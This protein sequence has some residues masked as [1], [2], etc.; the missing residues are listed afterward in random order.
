MFHGSV[1]PTPVSVFSSTST[2]PF[3]LFST[4]RDASLPQE[5]GLVLLI[6]STDSTTV[7]T[8]TYGNTLS[9]RRDPAHFYLRK[10]NQFLEPDQVKRRP[11]RHK[12]EGRYCEKE[13]GERILKADGNTAAEGSAR[14]VERGSRCEEV[15]ALLDQTVL[16]LQ[17]PTIATTFIRSP[18]FST[19]SSLLE[20]QLLELAI[21]LPFVHF[22]L[23]SI[24]RHLPFL[25][26]VGIKD[27]KGQHA[28]IRVSTFQTRP[29]LYPAEAPAKTV[30]DDENTN[31]N[32]GASERDR[33]ARELSLRRGPLLHLPID[34][35]A[36]ISKSEEGPAKE[37]TILTTWST[38]SLDLSS[39]LAHFNNS[40]LISPP[41]TNFVVQGEPL[42]ATFQIPQ[43]FHK[44]R[45]LT[46]VQVHANCRLRRI[47]CDEGTNKTS[48][49]EFRFFTCNHSPS[50]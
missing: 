32:S 43:I 20:G 39:L 48:L 6:D 14:D 2:N 15:C 33:L 24:D 10:G 9:S 30:V 31:D 12:K 8:T 47:W 46:Y 16:H 49:D 42:Q 27:I 17:S 37:R 18:P 1:I 4:H 29:V 38:L 11:G 19:R 3:S 28:R 41:E 45:H 26:E 50:P 13:G 23:R 34:V 5:S 40:A 21:P 36:Q 44:F 22:Q 25:V 35:P 7:D